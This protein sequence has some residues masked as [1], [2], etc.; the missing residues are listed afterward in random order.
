MTTTTILSDQ[1]AN[2]SVKTNTT[3]PQ[4]IMVVI[5]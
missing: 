3:L 5:T 2:T 4:E 1:V